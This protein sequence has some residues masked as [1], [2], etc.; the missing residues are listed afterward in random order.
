MAARL[1]AMAASP[2]YFSRCRYIAY[3]FH[4]VPTFTYMLT[5]LGLPL[6]RA[7]TFYVVIAGSLARYFAECR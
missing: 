4:G 7:D 3:A 5:H 6:R 1:H 2:F